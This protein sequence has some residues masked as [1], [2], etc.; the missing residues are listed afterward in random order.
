M[1]Y[2]KTLRQR[3]ELT[4]L[5]DHQDIMFGGNITNFRGRED[6]KNDPNWHPELKKAVYGNA[7]QDHDPSIQNEED[8]QNYEALQDA[9]FG[10]YKAKE[11]YLNDLYD[12]QLILTTGKMH[13]ESQ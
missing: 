3:N 6:L 12:N 4:E 7:P 1:K 10:Y 13:R 8:A 11:D 5:F 9:Q 2:E